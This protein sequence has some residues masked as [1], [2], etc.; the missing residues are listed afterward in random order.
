MIRRSKY[1]AQKATSALIGR[2]FDS[3]LERDWGEHCALRQ[4][5]GEI[6]DLEFQVAYELVVNGIWIGRYTCDAQYRE[7]G[8]LHVTDPKGQPSRDYRLR[9]KLMVACHGIVVE[10]VKRGPRGEWKVSPIKYRRVR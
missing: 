2:H 9:V 3:K 8:V 6:Q 10:E 7:N 4:K 1:G 5:A